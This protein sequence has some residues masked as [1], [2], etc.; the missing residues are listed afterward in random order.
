MCWILNHNNKNILSIFFV[1]YDISTFCSVPSSILFN[2]SILLFK[3]NEMFLQILDEEQNRYFSVTFFSSAFRIC[4]IFCSRGQTMNS[5]SHNWREKFPRM[6]FIN[7]V[8]FGDW[9]VALST[10]SLLSENYPF[11][12]LYW[13]I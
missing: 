2:T 10:P 4:K 5:P 3:M 9:D 6:L 7:H 13:R 8:L 1:L 11:H 12:T